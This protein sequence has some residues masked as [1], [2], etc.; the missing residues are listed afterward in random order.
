MGVWHNDVLAFTRRN[1]LFALQNITITKVQHVSAYR[2]EPV[3][4]LAV[5]VDKR[6]YPEVSLN[7][8]VKKGNG[9]LIEKT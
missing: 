4:I 3:E 8:I 7:K 1:P 9:F 2:L 6:S 5:L